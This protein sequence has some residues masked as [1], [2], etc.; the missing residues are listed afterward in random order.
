MNA[1]PISTS[2]SEATA[3]CTHGSAPC[4]R[5]G[6][7]ARL[8]DDHVLAVLMD[9]HQRLLGKLARLREIADHDLPRLPHVRRMELLEEVLRIAGAL[10]AAEPHHQREEKVL[11]PALRARGLDGPPRVMLAEHEH[12]RALKH[13][14]ETGALHALRRTGQGWTELMQ[15]ARA[16]ARDLE[17]HIR[18]EDEVLYPMALQVVTDPEEWAAMKRSCDQV[19]YCCHAHA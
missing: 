15:T 8:A 7:R 1:H 6:P 18:K 19:G 16:L 3:P 5:P 12:L 9:E 4:A 11:F 2:F 10:L 14:L 17:S 13:R